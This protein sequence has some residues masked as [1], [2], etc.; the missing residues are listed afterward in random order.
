[1]EILG[2]SVQILW[3]KWIGL[4]NSKTDLGGSAE[5]CRPAISFVLEAQL[6]PAYSTSRYIFTERERI[7]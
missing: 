3:V 1:M 5:D 7:W 2:F 4:W 6:L